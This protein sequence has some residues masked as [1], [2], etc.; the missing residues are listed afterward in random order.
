MFKSL[1]HKASAVKLGISS[2]QRLSLILILSKHGLEQ[3]TPE[4]RSQGKFL[5]LKQRQGI[6]R[7]FVS[8]PLG[9]YNDS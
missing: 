1:S 5:S 9:R 6:N 3:A 2:S 4:V 7:A 8:L